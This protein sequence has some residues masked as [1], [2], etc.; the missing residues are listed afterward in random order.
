M[1]YGPDLDG[2]CSD[3]QYKSWST[4]EE[5]G[6]EWTP[7]PDPWVGESW[8]STVVAGMTEEVSSSYECWEL[9]VEDHMAQCHG[10]DTCSFTAEDRKVSVTVQPLSLNSF[11]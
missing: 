8:H 3:S 7:P 11:I 2:T 5:A 6:A 9:D 10:A 1:L 4:C